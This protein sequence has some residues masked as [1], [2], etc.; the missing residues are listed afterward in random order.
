ME[1]LCKNIKR[2]IRSAL[3]LNRRNCRSAW[4]WR[5]VRSS[6]I[7]RSAASYAS[8]AFGGQSG[9]S[10][11]PSSEMRWLCSGHRCFSTDKSGQRD[12][13]ADGIN[14]SSS[15]GDAKNSSSNAAGGSSADDSRANEN[16]D[17]SSSGNGSGRSSRAQQ[18]AQRVAEE[19][20]QRN[21]SVALKAAA[22]VVLT[23]GLSYAFVPL[24]QAFCQAT[25]YGGTTQRRKNTEE[26]LATK[27]G[28]EKR[29]VT[30]YFNADV[31]PHLPWKFVPSQ[32][33]V[34]CETGDT[35]LAFFRAT[36]KTDKPIVGISTYNVTPMK[37]GLYFHKIQ[38][39]KLY[40][41]FYKKKRTIKSKKKKMFDENLHNSNRNS[42]VFV[43]LTL[44]FFL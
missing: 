31:S 43:S 4:R 25:G 16:G 40:Y 37:A 38:C 39:C 32:R 36:N 15:A 2:M 10:H 14:L 6:P 19:R 18:H 42:F 44:V 23:L 41:F 5:G 22:V 1:P 17:G 3:F 34:Q 29:R 11:R 21:E 9:A 7:A 28:K 26:M 20:R 8:S 24:Y 35:V 30:V 27:D 33:S 13:A 12:K